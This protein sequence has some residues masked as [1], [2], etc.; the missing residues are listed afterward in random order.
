MNHL[1]TADDVVEVVK[2]R[3]FDAP[4]S[5][6]WKVWTEV[7]H[8][9]QWWGRPGFTTVCE[10]DLRPGGKMSIYM[11]GPD[12]TVLISGTV[13]EVIANE[14]LVTAGVLEIDGVAALNTRLDVSFAE[15]AGMTSV[16]VRHTFWNFAGDRNDMLD[17]ASAGWNEQMERLEAYLRGRDAS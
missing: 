10:H 17:G 1:E 8:R 6:V 13:E 15:H 2:T 11:Q 4:L 14:R 9:N 16:T 3:T 12:T 7:E 5:L